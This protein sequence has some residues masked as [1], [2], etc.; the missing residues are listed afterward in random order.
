[1]VS[2][3]KQAVTPWGMDSIRGKDTHGY[4][5]SKLW[6]QEATDTH[7]HTHTHTHTQT[8]TH[9]TM[10]S[11]E[12]QH[13]QSHRHLKKYS[14]YCSHGLVLVIPLSH[15]THTHTHT[16]KVPFFFPNEGKII[17]RPDVLA[18][19][20]ASHCWFTLIPSTNDPTPDA[21]TRTTKG[22][23]CVYACIRVSVNSRGI[24]EK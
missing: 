18:C 11:S 19:L 24:K 16:L 14:V 22:N 15:I 10:L 3:Y 5:L 9:T 21:M 12:R 20:P 4:A 1:M 6:K 23:L 8:W 17:S 13:N 7:T 2:A